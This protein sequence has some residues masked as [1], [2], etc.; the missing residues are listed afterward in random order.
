MTFEQLPAP[1]SHAPFR[2]GPLC[3]ELVAAALLG[4]L[5]LAPL[6]VVAGGGA[7]APASARSG[8]PAATPAP[9][10]VT[11]AASLPVL[12]PLYEAVAPVAT[13]IAPG[14]AGVRVSFDPVTGAMI[15]PRAD[16]LAIATGPSSTFEPY[17]V[18]HADGTVTAYL[19]DAFMS[20]MVARRDAT[21]RWWMTCVDG[22]P[23]A[24]RA[25]RAEAPKARPVYTER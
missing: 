13:D 25:L 14:T 1:R 19:G 6:P 9:A 15:P 11:V 17:I 3:A 5:V 22:A 16:A 24:E 21:G 4:V 12:P 7:Q 2:S 23:A 20:W 18:H 10:A 8:A